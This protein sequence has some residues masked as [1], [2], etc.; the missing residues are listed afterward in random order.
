MQLKEKIE[1]FKM[2]VSIIRGKSSG[3]ILCKNNKKTGLLRAGNKI[4]LAM[5]ILS[6]MNGDKSFGELMANGVLGFIAVKEYVPSS[7][8]K[9]G[10]AKVKEIIEKTIEE[11]QK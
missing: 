5:L 10:L 8:T 4:D 1:L 7:L 11:G 3:I 6:N 2:S 9:E